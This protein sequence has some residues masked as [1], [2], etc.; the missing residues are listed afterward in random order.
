MTKNLTI[1]AGKKVF[2]KIRDEGLHPD[3]VRVIAGPAGGPKWL[4]LSHL[5]RVLFSSWF[6]NR[7]RPLFL[8]GSSSGAWRF[9]SVSQADPLRAI[10]RFQNAYINQCY[11]SDPSPEEVSLE[12]RNILDQIMGEKGPDEILS[13]PYLRLNIMAVRCRGPVA[14]DKKITQSLSMALA[15]LCNGIHRRSLKFFFERVLFY[16][17]RNIPPF[18][19]MDGFPILKIPLNRENIRPA[20]LASGAI[21]L[22]MSGVK[23]IPGGPAGIYRDGGVIDYHMDIPFMKKQK[24]LVL[25]FHYTDHIIPGWLDKKVPWRKPYH[26]DDVVLVS[27][28]Q[29]FIEHLPYKKIPDRTDFYRFK[30]QD[31][32]RMAYWNKA[33]EL[34]KVLADEFME[35]VQT[36]RIGELVIRPQRF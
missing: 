10:D 11:E 26:M 6:E 19:E 22:V 32:E 3:D 31:P 8:I 2:T 5:D 4:I 9:A 14:S 23:D 34:S 7:T 33:V 12:A 16:D 29:T 17:P 27:P 35:L 18:F 20:L 36:N 30:G 1:I 28:S 15:A 21:P 24:G 25:F 13:H